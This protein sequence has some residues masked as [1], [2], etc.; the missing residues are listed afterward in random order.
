MREI[1][2][3]VNHNECGECRVCC[4]TFPFTGEA[5]WADQYNEVPH[6]QEKYDLIYSTGQAC[7]QL[8]ST[9]C[10]IQHDKPKICKEF[11]CDYLKYELPEKFYPKNCGFASYIY[12]KTIGQ[13]P[14]LWIIIDELPDVNKNYPNDRCVFIQEDGSFHK[15]STLHEVLGDKGKEVRNYVKLMREHWGSHITAKIFTRLEWV[16]IP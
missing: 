6:F 14:E 8:C 1:K 16:E 9:G 3:H 11:W 10:S 5:I 12:D 7:N 2:F 13:P 15:F 4:T